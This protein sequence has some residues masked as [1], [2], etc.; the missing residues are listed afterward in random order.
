MKF[1]VM[2]DGLDT[3][4][5]R[6]HYTSTDKIKKILGWGVFVASSAVIAHQ[7]LTNKNEDETD[8]E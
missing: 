3:Y 2:K 5:V 1:T 4:D 6:L 7:Y 8:T